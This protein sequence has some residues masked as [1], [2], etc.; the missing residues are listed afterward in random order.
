MQGRRA[1]REFIW[2]GDVRDRPT[3]HKQS[4]YAA[5]HVIQFIGKAFNPMFFIEYLS[6]KNFCSYSLQHL[7]LLPYICIIYSI[8]SSC[9][10]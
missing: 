7:V 8:R 9:I 5:P 1:S 4:W 2:G 3:R 6:M 10:N